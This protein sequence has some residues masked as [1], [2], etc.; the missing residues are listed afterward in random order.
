MNCEIVAIGSELL[1]PFRQ[2]TNS[3]FLTEHLNR[4]GVRVTFKTI[5]GDSRADLVEVIRA[6]LA[7]T[8]IVILMGGLGPTE[9]DL[10]R[11]AAAEALGIEL[12]RDETLLEELRARFAARGLK[13]TENNN[14]QADVLAGAQI[15]KNAKGSAPG[16]YVQIPIQGAMRVVILLPGPPHELKAMFEEQVLDRLLSFVPRRAIATRVLKVAMVGESAL[17]ARIAGIYRQYANVQT[18]ILAHGGEVQIHLQTEADEPEQAQEIVN[19]LAGKIEDELDDRVFSAQGESLEEIVNYYLQMRGASLA[20]SESCTGGLLAQ[21][22]TSVS[23]ASRSFLGGVVAYSN[24]LKIQLSGVAPLLIAEH[25]AVS[26]EVAVAMAEGIRERCRA[27]LGVGITGIAGP[28]GGTETKPVG[29]VYV[30][31]SGL[32]ETQVVE[33]RFPGDRERIRWWASQQALDMIRKKL[34]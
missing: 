9:D 34:M 17:D 3:L 5:V 13:M 23:G 33:R 6:A 2:D 4:L 19:E 25:G 26:R 10:T 1:T 31:I 11:E 12:H 27:T 21:R 18:T 28:G 14:K 22:I 29:L 16:Q 32:G 7:R 8:N 24:D 20:V 15:L 30:A